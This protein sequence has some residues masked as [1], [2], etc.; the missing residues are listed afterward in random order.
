M[1]REISNA[2]KGLLVPRWCLVLPHSHAKTCKH[3]YKK[4]SWNSTVI[5]INNIYNTLHLLISDIASSYI[6]FFY[7]TTILSTRGLT[8]ANYREILI[9]W[10]KGVWS[11]VMSIH[12]FS[13]FNEVHVRYIFY[14]NYLSGKS[15][16][17]GK[18][19]QIENIYHLVEWTCIQICLNLK[20][21]FNGLYASN[22]CI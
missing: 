16:Y 11:S 13:I 10:H 20:Y 21:I 2:K 9:C 18:I 3:T 14:L 5:K 19:G 17:L 22:V 1:I 6:I 4:R 8:N 15:I 7:W 12:V